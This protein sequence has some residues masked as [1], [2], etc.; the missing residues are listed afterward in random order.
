MSTKKI[1]GLGLLVFAVIKLTE[2]PA[3]ITPPP[4]PGGNLQNNY[5]A[6]LAYAKSVTDQA[7]K[8]YGSVQNAINVLW[9][10]G[11]PFNNTPVPQYDAGTLFW[12]DVEGGGVAGMGKIYKFGSSI[13][14]PAFWCNDHENLSYPYSPGMCSYHGG[15]DY[16]RVNSQAAQRAYH[17]R[18]Q[19]LKQ[20]KMGAIYPSIPALYECNDGTYSTSNSPRGC[21]RHGG[22]K[23]GTPVQ[24]SD[25]YSGLLNI[26]D[27][28]IQN[29]FVDTSLFQGR[30]KEY[31]ERSVLNIVNDAED[32]KFLWENLDPI[33]LWQAPDG[34]LYLLSG[35]SRLTAF[36]RL[37]AKG[38]QAQGKDFTR[39]PAK[40]LQ[41]VPVN[42]AQTV[43]LESNTLSTKE[44]DLERAIY[45]RKLRQDGTPERTLLDTIKRNE[46]RNWPNVYA[47]T[48]LSPTGATWYT[49]RQFGESED[50]SANLA[51]SLAK[52]IGQ[53]RKS[54]PMLT[55][56]HENELF[57]WL[58]EQKGYGSGRQQVNNEREFLERVREFIQKNTFFGQFDTEKPLNIQNLLS[59]SPV[60]QEYDLQIEAAQREMQEAEADVR[61]KI[62]QLALQKASPAD[63]QRITAPLET[64]ARN[65]RLNLQRLMQQRSNVI[66]YSKNEPSLFGRRIRGL[67]PAWAF[68]LPGV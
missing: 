32:G 66:E 3:Y 19:R 39:I 8:L 12:G 56:D 54:F 65:A 55:N 16:R 10:P 49:I 30:E 50:T 31:S 37:S 11:G 1:I 57:R 35:H 62:K 24:L 23:T 6:W 46:G 7:V 45:Y 5:A 43:A 13:P 25:N 21:Q 63:V 20:I 60:E 41:N 27:V 61:A 52:W 48:F 36:K 15:V 44:T 4:K 17:K 64:R 40:I 34:K 14:V 47:Y 42:V 58:F 22:K 28:P 18:Q 2:Q 67:S 53:A 38:L 59:K 9:G 51:K 68:L 29:I 26:R 33:T